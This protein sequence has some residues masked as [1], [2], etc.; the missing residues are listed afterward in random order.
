M[1]WLHTR[2]VAAAADG[3]CAADAVGSQ[4][5]LRQ[6]QQQRRRQHVSPSLHAAKVGWLRCWAWWLLGQFVVPLLRNSFYVTESEPY[7]QEVFYYRCAAD[8]YKIF[9]EVVIICS[10]KL[11]VDSFF[12]SSPLSSL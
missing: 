12:T 5:S 3:G 6:Q 11:V 4:Q 10:W 9:Y 8:S 2:A 7:R 1:T